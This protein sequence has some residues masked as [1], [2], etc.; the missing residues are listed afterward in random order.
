MRGV[1]TSGR[2]LGA[3]PDSIQIVQQENEINNPNPHA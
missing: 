3:W 1:E 2:V